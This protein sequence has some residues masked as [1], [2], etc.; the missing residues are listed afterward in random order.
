MKHMLDGTIHL[1]DADQDEEV[2]LHT[3][4]STHC[5]FVARGS[6]SGHNG[7]PWIQTA[8]GVIDDTSLVVTK[9]VD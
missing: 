8:N 6:V 2:A 5:D 9:G 3:I 4:S 1:L 7:V